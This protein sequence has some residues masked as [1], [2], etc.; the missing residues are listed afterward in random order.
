M[1]TQNNITE[2]SAEN[3]VQPSNNFILTISLY[4]AQKYSGR[5]V[6]NLCAHTRHVI[7]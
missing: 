4:P 3:I 1:N 5:F 2:H 7:F 6:Q